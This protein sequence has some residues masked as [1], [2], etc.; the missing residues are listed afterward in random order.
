MD[1][2]FA[3]FQSLNT[4]LNRNQNLDQCSNNDWFTQIN[5]HANKFIILSSAIDYLPLVVSRDD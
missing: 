3:Q 5:S 4:D 1:G 2:E